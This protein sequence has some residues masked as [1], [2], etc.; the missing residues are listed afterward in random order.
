[1]KKETKTIIL[2]VMITL[3]L[4]ILVIAL[5]YFIYYHKEKNRNTDKT[6]TS[7]MNENY[8]INYSHSSNS[9][10][11]EE[12][13]TN[14]DDNSNTEQNNKQ[15]N[16]SEN[17]DKKVT[18]YIFRGEGCPH[19]ESVIEFMTSI[20]NHYDYLE[21]KSLEIWYHEDNSLLAR[22][23]AEKFNVELTGVPFI[24]IGSEYQVSGFATSMEDELKEAIVSAYQNDA[25]QDVVEELIE[26]NNYDLMIENL[27][28]N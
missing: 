3:L 14:T 18:V 4:L 24:V 23:V 27:K 2:G 9:Q 12:N 19:C 6:N 5:L 22:K 17:N 16:D 10:I 11:S 28:E 15:N 26:Q 8:N 25:Y 13:N 1:M 21:V 7:S 20:F